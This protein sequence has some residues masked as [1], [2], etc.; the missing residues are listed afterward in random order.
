MYIYKINMSE[1]HSESIISNWDEVVETFEEMKLK[2]DLLH[3]ILSYGFEKPSMIQQRAIKPVL[4]GHDCIAQAQSGTGKT[5]TFVI[6]IL[7]KINTDLQECQAIIVAPTRELVHQII[8][9]MK[10]LS[11]HMK[12]II[13]SCVGGTQVSNDINILKNGVHVVV[14]CPGRTYDMIMRRA[15]SLKEVKLFVIDEADEMLSRGFKEQI[16][17]IFKYHSRF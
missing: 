13:H 14:G 4:L 7:E 8:N 15:L 6:S 9:V 3:G 10:A 2:K 17:E 16:Y 11:S 1:I 5:A 12:C